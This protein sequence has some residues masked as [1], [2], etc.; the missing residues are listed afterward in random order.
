MEDK[1]EQNQ[2]P[3]T[4]EKKKDPKRVAAGKRLEAISRI[5]KERKKKQMS[6]VNAVDKSEMGGE[7]YD[8]LLLTA[9]AI[10]ISMASKKLLK[11]PLGT[12]ENTKGMLKL[13]VSLSLSSLL[14]SYLKKHKYIPDNP[15]KT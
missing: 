13:A 2:V 4:S 5:A 8:A 6:K 1:P 9:G 3:V 15:I 10:G 14:V 11:E 12:P 7:V